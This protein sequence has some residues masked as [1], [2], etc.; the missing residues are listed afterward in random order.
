[1][2]TKREVIDA[3]ECVHDAHVPASLRSMGMLSDVTVGADGQVTVALCLPCMACP[4]VSYLCE[5]VRQA[6]ACRDGVT[7]VDVVTA[8]HLRWE[9]ES[10]DEDARLLMRTHGIQL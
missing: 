10:V 5:Q 6:I 4:A 1:M 3:L 2:I 9:P 7:E 8:W